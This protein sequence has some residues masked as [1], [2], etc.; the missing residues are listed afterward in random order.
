VI[1][2]QETVEESIA[3]FPLAAGTV[4]TPEIMPPQMRAP[5]FMAPRIIEQEIEDREGAAQ[6]RWPN[7]IDIG[8]VITKALTAA[9]LLK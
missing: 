4:V 2:V 9:G 6:S 5:Q 7:R 3:D 1:D 8:A